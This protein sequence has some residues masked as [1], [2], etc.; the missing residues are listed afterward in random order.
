MAVKDVTFSSGGAQVKIE[1]LRKALRAFEAAG[2]SAEDMKDLMHS[3]GLIVVATATPNAPTLSGALAGSLRAG[4]GKT[5]AVVRAGG[6]RVPYAGVQHYGWPARNIAA[7]PFLA[8]AV[9]STRAKTFAALEDGVG[10]LLK[11]QNLT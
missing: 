11:K 1:G 7:K 2:A 3:I 9:Q 6:A 5:K 4:R 8:D 10:D